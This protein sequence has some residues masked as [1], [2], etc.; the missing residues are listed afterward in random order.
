[1]LSIWILVRG[2]LLKAIIAVAASIVRLRMIGL[3]VPRIVAETLLLR[4][5]FPVRVTVL[6]EFST[7]R[8]VEFIPTSVVMLG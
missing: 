5:L 7:F 3:L 2:D 8:R 1:M 4:T 6:C